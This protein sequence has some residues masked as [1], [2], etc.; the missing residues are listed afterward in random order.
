VMKTTSFGVEEVTMN[1]VVASR[2]AILNNQGVGRSSMP[3]SKVY[4]I[5]ILKF[6]LVFFIYLF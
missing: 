4:S 1:P 3:I 6:L 5:F 2:I